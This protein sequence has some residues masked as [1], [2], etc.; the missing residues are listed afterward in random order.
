M[1]ENTLRIIKCF[2]RIGCGD[3]YGCKYGMQIGRGYDHI[4]NGQETWLATS[5][6]FNHRISFLRTEG[7][8][9]FF[10]CGWLGIVLFSGSS[11]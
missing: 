10:T 11:S 8:G 3:T 2:A 7:L 9:I 4:A 6:G 5:V 1:C